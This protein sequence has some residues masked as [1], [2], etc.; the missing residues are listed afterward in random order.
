MQG[1]FSIKKQYPRM[2][3]FPV[4]EMNDRGTVKAQLLLSWHPYEGN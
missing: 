4:T 3:T 2:I 1:L